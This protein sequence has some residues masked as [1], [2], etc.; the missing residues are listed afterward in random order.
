MCSD[1][2]PDS[3]YELIYFIVRGTRYI[4]EK[5]IFV[6]PRGSFHAGG[7]GVWHKVEARQ[8]N[9]DDDEDPDPGKS[10]RR[11]AAIYFEINKWFVVTEQVHSA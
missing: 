3:G 2:F 10:I 7:I 1:V 6:E 9:T 4:V 11:M 8:V 5:T